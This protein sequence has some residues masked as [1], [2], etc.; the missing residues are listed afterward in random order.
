[1]SDIV[2]KESHSQWTLDSNQVV[3]EPTLNEYYLLVSGCIRI[4]YVNQKGES[5][6]V[7]LVLP[8]DYLG[9]ERFTESQL[10]IEYVTITPCTIQ[11]EFAVYSELP[12]DVLKTVLIQSYKRCK[13]VVAYLRCGSAQ[14]RLTHLLMMMVKPDSKTVMAKTELNCLMPSIKDMAHIVDVAPESISRTIAS[15]KKDNV[16]A[17]RKRFTAQLNIS[18]LQPMAA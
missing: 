9:V 15:L 18:H 12:A 3:A 8:G 6:F 1:M 13:D 2:I 11:R 10:S 16:L 7:R 17:N 14:E 4:N 5:T